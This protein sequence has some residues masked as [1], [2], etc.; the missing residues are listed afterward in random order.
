MDGGINRWRE[1]GYIPVTEVKEAAV[2]VRVLILK[3]KIRPAAQTVI[4][5]TQL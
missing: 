1:Y 5:H 3:T 2:V 4:S